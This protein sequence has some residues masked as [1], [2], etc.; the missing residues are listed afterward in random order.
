[1]YKARIPVPKSFHLMGV[2]DPSKKLR[3]GEI[4]VR[5]TNR[6]NEVVCGCYIDCVYT[7][8]HMRECECDQVSEC[9]SVCARVCVGVWACAYVR[10]WLVCFLS[11]FFQ[12]M[13]V[14]VELAVTKSPC[15]HPG[16]LRKLK[17]V[18][19]RELEEL[20][21]FVCV[22][23]YVHVLLAHTHTHTYTH[24]QTLLYS[25]RYRSSTQ[26][27]TVCTRMCVCVC[28]CVCLL[29]VCVCGVVWV[30]VVWVCGIIIGSQYIMTSIRHKGCDCLFITTNSTA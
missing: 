7:L 4:F 10:C 26:W 22:H 21:I 30:C 25:H 5:F 29:C 3:P 19:V 14:N 18:Y 24:T 17:A 15:L 20:G 16:D 12:E 11:Y 6:D 23:I 13:L 8:M 28:V 9:E 27:S 1:M 2:P